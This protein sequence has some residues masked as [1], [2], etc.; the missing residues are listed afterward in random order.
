MGDRP[1]RRGRRQRRRPLHLLRTRAHIALVSTLLAAVAAGC[2]G[3]GSSGGQ[4]PSAGST[5]TVT[6]AGAPAGGTRFAAAG[7]SAK[8]AGASTR[9]Q[10]ATFA[11]LVN[12]RRS[13]LPG[14]RAV[15]RKHRRADPGHAGTLGRCLARPNHMKAVLK[16][17]TDRFRLGE[18]PAS[19]EA[20]SE[21]EIAPSARAL[22]RETA[23]QKAML[24]QARTL[25]CLQKGIGALAPSS[26]SAHGVKI[27]IHLG[28]VKIAPIEGAPPPGTD[29]EIG[30]TIKFVVRYR[31]T[32]RGQPVDY[33]LAFYL[34][35]VAFNV[36][37][38]QVTLETSGQSR[39][40]PA[41]EELRLLSTLVSRALSARQAVPAVG[42]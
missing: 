27:A 10:Y 4:A 33:P 14:S 41:N 7:T 32:L 15:A 42:A 34:D 9:E 39:P 30:M 37:R 24:H 13:D 23:A 16:R 38:A 22:A 19:V 2:G 25:S 12:L 1:A 18:E 29:A 26:A 40:F 5:A 8:A 35:A 28:G 31:F 21:V 11:N 36:G 17:G 6:A 20:S 3:S